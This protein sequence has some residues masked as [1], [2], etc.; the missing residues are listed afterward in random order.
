MENAVV[1]GPTDP[2]LTDC[3]G[4]AFHHEGFRTVIST[5]L[6]R[7]GLLAGV[8]VIASREVSVVPKK[9]IVVDDADQQSARAGASWHIRSDLRG[10]DQIV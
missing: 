5:P 4:G 6:V 7:Q 9:K 1:L 10:G 2:R 8:L 3:T